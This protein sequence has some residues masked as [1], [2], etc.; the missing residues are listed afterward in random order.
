MVGKYEEGNGFGDGSLEPEG[1]S[2]IDSA[3]GVSSKYSDGVAGPE[4]SP[5]SSHGLVLS[6]SAGVSA[7]GVNCVRMRPNGSSTLILVVVD[8]ADAFRP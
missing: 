6:I 5:L 2:E 7:R 3:R 1:R 4:K 8:S